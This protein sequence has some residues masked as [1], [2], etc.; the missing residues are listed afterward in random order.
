MILKTELQQ[1]TF[2]HIANSLGIKPN[3][4]GSFYLAGWILS[5]SESNLK[6]IP[7]FQIGH[8]AGWNASRLTH[9]MEKH[10][11]E[12]KAAMAR[13]YTSAEISDIPEFLA[14]YEKTFGRPI[15][16]QS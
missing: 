11:R 1:K 5:Y 6:N 10:D 4:P 7:V 16:G 12:C 9:Y 13:D 8:A 2:N 3:G 15:S 14:A